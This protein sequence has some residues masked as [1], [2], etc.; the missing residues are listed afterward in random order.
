[1]VVLCKLVHEFY[2]DIEDPT[3][4]AQKTATYS[5]VVLTP[6]LVLPAEEG[7]EGWLCVLD[8]F[9][10]IFCKFRVLERLRISLPQG[11]TRN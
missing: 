1:V 10:C 6:S 3:A 5:A 7:I 11:M 4:S 2:L 9:L 8:S